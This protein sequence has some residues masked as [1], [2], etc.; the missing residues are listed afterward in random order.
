[1]QSNTASV[2]NQSISFASFSVENRKSDPVTIVDGRYVGHDGFVVPKN[3][4]EFHQR[5]PEYV[6]IWVR[7]HTDRSTPKQ[8]VE[9]WTQDLLL[10]LH[11][12]PPNSKHR[13][14]GKQDVVQT[15]DPHRHYGANSAR[16]FN[17]I[18]GC[19]GN[20]F[21]TM[22]SSRIK[23]PICRAGNLSLGTHSNDEDCGQVEDEFCHAH[24]AHL[25]GR[26]QRQERQHDARQILARFSAFVE[27][28]DSSVL[29]AMDA[30]AATATPG[31]A[32]EL[33]GATRADFSR[34]R[35]RL[36]Q[37]SRCF[38]TGEGVP[39]QRRRYRRRVAVRISLRVR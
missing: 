34:M 18:N 15:F 38:Q 33:L 37:L 26:C 6:R 30:I 19:L 25:R 21:S 17:Y 10:H 2:G 11:C 35:S 29:P 24:S 32:A 22:R 39:R 31:G 3:F 1:M 9:D 16:F 8:D 27:R 12:L 28:E 13:E 14:T 23:N 36:R 5:F 7:R 20:K 4:D